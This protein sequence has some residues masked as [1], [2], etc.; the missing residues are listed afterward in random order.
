MNFDLLGDPIPE[1]WGRRGRPPHVPTDEKRKL[2]IQLAA[3]DWTNER[4]AGALNCSE[5]T[6][7]KHYFRELKF[8]NEAK[9][10]VQAKLL[11]KLMDQVEQGNVS[12]ITRYQAR[13]DKHDL[14]KKAAAQQSN[15]PG[16]SA[17]SL[18]KKEGLLAQAKKVGGLF[19]TPNA[20]GT[21]N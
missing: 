2:V 11:S 13:I 21:V 12:A 1:N 5:P 10:R 16:T 20:P 19:A 3:F 14:A 4:I 15:A 18:G 8:K 7:R 17:K 6:L 9:D